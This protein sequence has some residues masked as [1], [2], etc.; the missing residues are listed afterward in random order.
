MKNVNVS[1]SILRKRKMM[2]VLPALVIPFMT[3]AF[4]ALGGGKANAGKQTEEK[5]AMGLNLHVPDPKLKKETIFDK[6]GFYDQ[7]DKVSMKLKE[8]M[9]NDP[10]YQEQQFNEQEEP[11]GELETIVQHSAGK[12]HQTSLGDE[13]KL[14]TSPYNKSTNQAEEQLMQKLAALNKVISQ[15][16]TQLNKIDEY[17]AIDE[18]LQSDSKLDGSVSRLENMLQSMNQTNDSDP[19]LD[20]LSGMMDKIIT[21]QHPEKLK[22]ELQQKSKEQ[23]TQVFAVTSTSAADTIVNGFYSL[24]AP[25]EMSKSNAI[26]AVVNEDQV[27]VSGAVIKLRLI[28]DA[29][30]KKVKIPAGNFVFGMV[31][32]DG[33]RLNIEI[34]SIRY[35]NALYPVKMEVY[36]MDGLKGIYI[37]GAINRD[38]AKQSADNSLQT[39]QLTA[40]DPSLAAQA[41]SA[42]ISTVKN[43]LSKKVKLVKVMVKAGYKILLKDASL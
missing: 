6:L 18:N 17:A 1:Q 34:N 5:N 36:D 39:M 28:S 20:Q 32:L 38:V 26:E 25:E 43:L 23:K 29:F 31:T 9:R 10:F 21:I 2:L 37:P 3:L 12:F 42:G 16:Q 35:G 14:K 30:I 40:M 22:E 27:L 33:E 24:D 11:S 41:T 13:N 4:W 15:P 19:E 7:A 8:Q